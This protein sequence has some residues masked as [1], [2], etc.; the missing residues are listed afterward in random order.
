MSRTWSF[1]TRALAGVLG[2]ALLVGGGSALGSGSASAAP[3]SVESR[4]TS[5]RASC[6]TPFTASFVASLARDFPRQ[7]VTASVH[8]TR[9]GCWYELHPRLRITTAST[10]KASV[11]GAVLLRAQDRRRGLTAPQLL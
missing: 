11:M 7:R 1:R 8:D 2:A 9:T 10:I 6:A 4:V 3:T 5:A